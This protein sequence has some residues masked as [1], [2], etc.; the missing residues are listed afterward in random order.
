[1]EIRLPDKLVDVFLGEA[2]VRGAYGGRGS[3]KTHSFAEMIA[4]HARRFAE[5]GVR[6]VMLCG[7]QHMNSIKES[8]FAEIKEAITDNPELAPV[9]DLG[10]NYISTKGLPGRVDFIFR[11]LSANLDSIKSTA[12]ILICWVDEA[13]SVTDDAYMKLEPTLRAE[14]EGWN[15]ELWVTWNPEARNS[16]TDKRYRQSKDPRIKVVALNWRDNPW[17]PAKL[18]RQRLRD[19]VERP[20][21]YGWIWEGEYRG[22]VRGAVYGEELK[23]LDASDR[24]TNV[25]YDRT[26][27]VHLFWDLGRADKTAIWFV[28][29]VPFGFA[30]I[31]YYERSGKALDHFIQLLQSRGYVYGNCWLPHDAENE[32]LASRLTVAQQMRD[33]GFKVR[34][35]KKIRV[36]EGIN[37][38]RQVL[39]RCWFD[40]TRCDRESDRPEDG[41]SGLAA[42]RS[43]RYEYDEE[44][45]EFKRE[46]LHDWASHGADAF[47]Y[48]AIAQ[49]QDDE[50]KPK[51]QPKTRAKGPRSGA[52]SW[53]A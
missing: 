50:D 19:Q 15:A 52:Q 42:L 35:V 17:F 29:V 27:P 13:E 11:G 1:M 39:D 4:V 23:R 49:T 8:S 41:G 25:P 2:D 48:L 7:R 5:A 40:R 37:A 53:M 16:P 46:P 32:L 44:K 12:R 30:V 26:K 10:E 24:V 22:I 9:F 34:I 33:A 43:Y 31:D 6:G 21:E 45:K 38:A 47:R 20:D 28:Q 3:A 36:N 18:N 51:P 14:D